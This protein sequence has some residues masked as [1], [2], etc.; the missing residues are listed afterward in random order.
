MRINIQDDDS[1][2]CNI[3]NQQRKTKLCFLRYI[4]K[5]RQILSHGVQGLLIASLIKKILIWDNYINQ[6]GKP[7]K[8]YPNYPIFWAFLFIRVFCSDGAKAQLALE[9]LAHAGTRSWLLLMSSAGPQPARSTRHLRTW[10]SLLLQM[11]FHCFSRGAPT[12]AGIVAST[13]RNS[14]T[15]MVIYLFSI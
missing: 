9:A 12:M 6:S 4:H 10:P 2:N 14:F 5:D 13:N 15:L 11:H 8:I 3:Q 1:Q 7:S